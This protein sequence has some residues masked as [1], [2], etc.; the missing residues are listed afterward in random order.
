MKADPFEAEQS[1]LFKSQ[2]HRVS[3]PVTSKEGVK[4]KAISKELWLILKAIQDIG[5]DFTARELSN[6]SGIEYYVIQKRLSVL[7]RLGY[8]D[9]TGIKRGGQM[10]WMLI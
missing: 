1:T 8:I 10:V 6:H 2:F 5:R 3:D 4:T 9:R 7:Q